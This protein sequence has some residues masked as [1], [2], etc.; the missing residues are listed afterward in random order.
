[1][2]APEPEAPGLSPPGLSRRRAQ[3]RRIAPPAQHVAATGR[4][5]LRRSLDVARAGRLTILMGPTGYGKTT[6]LAQWTATLAD[7]GL[8]AAWYTA[9]DLDREPDMFLQMLALSL[10]RAGVDM[11]DMA[12][13]KA[14]NASPKATLDD[15][16]LRLEQFARPLVIVVDDYERVE[17]PEIARM[18]DVMVEALPDEIHL[19]LATRRKPQLNL[20]AL[21]AQGA[22]RIIDPA[23]LRLSEDE[24]AAALDLSPDTSELARIVEQTEGWPVAVQLYR[25]WRDRAG[26]HADA[27]GFGG[28]VEEVADYLAEQVMADLPDALRALV[29]DMAVLDYIEPA[30]ADRIRGRTDSAAQLAEIAA[31]LPTLVQRSA[32]EGEPAYRLHPLLADYA[33]AR[34]GDQVRRLHSEAARWFA[35]HERYAAAVRHAVLSS[36][37]AVQTRIVGALPFLDI[38]LAYGAGELRAILRE[39]PAALVATLPRIQLMAALAHFK[40]GAFGS[41]LAMLDLVRERSAAN[42]DATRDAR[43]VVECDALALIFLIYIDGPIEDCET[44]IAQILAQASA[45]PLLWAWCENA[46]IVVHQQRGDLAAARQSIIRA[47]EI[48]ETGG[49]LG[50]AEAHLHTHDML[51]MLAAGQLRQAGELATAMQRD[52]RTRRNA[53][54]VVAAMTQMTLAA[55]E[56]ERNYRERAGDTIRLALEQFGEGE[57]WFEQYAIA[58]PVIADVIARRHGRDAAIRMIETADARLKAR[59]MRCCTG[60]LH[61]LA[62]LHRA[63][64]M[65]AEAAALLRDP[66]LQRSAARDGAGISWRE[67]DMARRALVAAA[68]RAAAPEAACGHA[69]AMIDEGQRDDRIGTLIKGLVLLARASEAA[70]DGA[71]ADRAIAEA[72]RIACTESVTAAFVEEGAAIRPLLLRARTLIQAA[73]DQKHAEAILRTLDAHPQFRSPD[74]LSDREAEIVAHLAD[75]ASNKLIARR[76]GLTDNTVKFHLK[77]AYAKLGVSSRKEAVARVMQ[78]G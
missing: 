75:G 78:D 25:L 59:G 70:G 53:E 68:L 1:M 31:R 35:E 20:S 47:R 12:Q 42:G 46:M 18:I 60:L 32:S 37:A 62:G 54:P 5:L 44:R 57:A 38:F 3:L 13:R 66:A 72:V 29:I 50:F 28:Q 69:R 33:Q 27:P 34:D 8:A 71:E 22:V 14:G 16:L 56:H 39:T 76:L 41:A 40:T 65:S 51:I 30:L 6:A 64:G 4:A 15:M 48:Y 63:G 55:I 74:M 77:K 52:Q 45:Y 67:R 2:T 73:I 9:S 10:D 11:A 19:V 17:H 43:F 58:Y 49:M 24:I 26:R 23:E 7:R 61:A 36:N 21:R